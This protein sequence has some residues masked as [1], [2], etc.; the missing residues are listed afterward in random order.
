MF[1]CKTF[2][3]NKPRQYKELQCFN[4][5]GIELFLSTFLGHWILI[6]LQGA[7]LLFPH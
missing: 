7:A 5:S 2:K 4:E 6:G 1:V 3:N